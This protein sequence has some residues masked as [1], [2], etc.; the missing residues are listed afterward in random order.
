MYVGG[1]IRGVGDIDELAALAGAVPMLLLGTDVAVDA[2]AAITNL[3]LMLVLRDAGS[4]CH[5]CC[6]CWCCCTCWL[7]VLSRA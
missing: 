5:G 6:W 4:C 7:L 2:A 3:P 1:L